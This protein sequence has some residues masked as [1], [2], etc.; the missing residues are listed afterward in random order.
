MQSSISLYKSSA[1]S[2]CLDDCKVTATT[3]SIDTQA[4]HNTISMLPRLTSSTGVRRVLRAN[5]LRLQSTQTGATS[6]ATLTIPGITPEVRHVG[7]KIHSIA[8]M[9]S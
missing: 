6:T 3:E 4:L 8:G 5:A 1:Q 9:Q 2:Q 7:P